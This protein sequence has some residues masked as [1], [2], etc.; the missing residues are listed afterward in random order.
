[1]TNAL[2]AMGLEP[3]TNLGA[4]VHRK[5]RSLEVSVDATTKI[6]GLF[7]VAARGTAKPNSKERNCHVPVCLV[8]CACDVHHIGFAH[9]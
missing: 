1:M 8:T 4:G 6:I 5:V 9:P 3:K 7:D 2:R